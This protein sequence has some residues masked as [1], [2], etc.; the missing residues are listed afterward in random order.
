[1][2]WLSLLSVDGFRDSPVVYAELFGNIL[3]VGI[4]ICFGVI[5]YFLGHFRGELGAT[6]WGAFLRRLSIRLISQI[7]KFWNIMLNSKLSHPFANC[8][9]PQ[10]V[11][12][13]MSKSLRFF[14]QAQ[15]ACSRSHDD[16]R[17]FFCKGESTLPP[18]RG[19]LYAP[20]LTMHIQ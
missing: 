14:K 2:K 6:N 3:L 11:F 19:Y 17:V 4:R 20:I 16:V 15:T 13:A 7:I 5:S 9:N 10:T 18:K 12:L 1:M 8:R